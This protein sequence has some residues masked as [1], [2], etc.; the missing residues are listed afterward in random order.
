MTKHIA[1]SA[2]A[3]IQSGYNTAAKSFQ[4]LLQIRM[5]C[6]YGFPVYSYFYYFYLISGQQIYMKLV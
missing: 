3:H 6:Q 5:K 4:D 2:S 1:S